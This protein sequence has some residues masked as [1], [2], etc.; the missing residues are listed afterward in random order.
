ML[1]SLLPFLSLFLPHVLSFL[2]PSSCSLVF[3]V[4]QQTKHCMRTI[5]VRI[6]VAQLLMQFLSNSSFHNNSWGDHNQ[7]TLPSVLTFQVHDTADDLFWE[8]QMVFVMSSYYFKVI[9]FAVAFQM[10]TD[11]TVHE[12]YQKKTSFLLYNIFNTHEYICTT[13]EPTIISSKKLNITG[14]WTKPALVYVSE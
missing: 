9:L 14:F 3:T 10:F 1:F 5:P 6:Q 11:N 7:S 12:H 2:L 8:F 13:K 4:T